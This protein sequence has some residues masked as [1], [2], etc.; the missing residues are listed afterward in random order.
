VASEATLYLDSS[1]LVK[2]V[3]DESHTPALL[4]AV[5]DHKLLSSEIAITEVPR[6]VGRALVSRHG[7]PAQAARRAMEKLL[8]GLAYVPI[9]RPLLARAGSFSEAWLR[10]LDAIHV[11]SALEVEQELEAFISYDERQLAAAR[12]AGLLVRCPDELRR[13]RT[14]AAT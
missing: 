14:A 9:T 13:A 4:D 5:S 3:I 2:L 6:A 11:A 10:A 8:S 7:K 12:R 1:A